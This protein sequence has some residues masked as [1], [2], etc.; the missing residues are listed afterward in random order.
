[1]NPFVAN[2]K[3]LAESNQSYRK[4]METGSHSQ[5]VLMSLKP[6]EDILEETHQ[7]VDQII[8]VVDGT[9]EII[10]NNK[11]YILSNDMMIMIKAG[12]KHYV[13][14]TSIDKPLKLYTI[15]SPPEHA[16]RL[17]QVNKQTGGSNKYLIK[18][19]N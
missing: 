7:N 8:I 12:S 14:N 6:S 5:I 17:E 15:Y 4:V 19:E 2:I 18:Y 13:K 16:Y 1:M 3:Q 9:A 10:S 11:S